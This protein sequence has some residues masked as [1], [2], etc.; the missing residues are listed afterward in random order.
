MQLPAPFGKYEL[1]ER[2][3]TGGMAE[4][5]L[6]RSFG[7]AGFEKRLVIKR[8]R[9][10]HAEDPRFI[11]MFINEAKIAV[12]LNH[13]N[14]VQVY[15]LGRVGPSWYIAMEHLHGRDLTRLVRILR[16][17]ERRLP[18][19]VAVHTV[20]EA[21]RGLHYAHSM[22]DPDGNRLG[23]VHRDVSPHNLV[24]TFDGEVKLVDFGV[25]RLMNTR[26]G[27][28][29][30]GGG[31]RPGG[32][33][34]AYMSPEQANGEEVDPRSDVFSAGIVLWELIAGHRLFQHEDAQEKLRRVREAVI[35]DLREGTDVDDQL[36]AILTKALAKERADRYATAGALEEDLRTWL[37][38]HY[39]GDPRSA[40]IAEITRAFPGESDRT[41]LG[42][43]LQRLVADVE[44]LDAAEATMTAATPTPTETPVAGRLRTPDGERK[45]VVCVVVDVDGLTDLSLKLEPEDMFKQHYRMLR[46]VR[47]IVDRY[48][49][50]ILTAIDDQIVLLFGARRNHRDDPAR[51]IEC[52]L[53]L[54][55]QV[56]SLR[57]KGLQLELAIGVHAGEV[58][59][60][61]GGRRDTRYLARGNTTRYARRLSARAD[62][63]E[64]LVS[65]GIIRAT[66]T[67]F[68]YTRGPEILNRGGQPP[69]PSWHVESRRH[70]LR[71]AGKGP[72]LRRG[73]ELDVIRD[74]LLRL[75]SGNGAMLAL[76]GPAGTGKSRL[77]REIQSL[78]HRRGLPIYVARCSPY[79]EDP[80]M[81]PF[82]DLVRSV[83]GLPPDPTQSEITAVL[84]RLAQLGL[85]PRMIEVVGALLDS[86]AA[87]ADEVWTA[88]TRIVQ[89]LSADGALVLAVEDL[90]FLRP[91]EHRRVAQLVRSLASRPIFFLGTAQGPLP[92]DFSGLGEMV[93]LGAF[94]S[95]V[96]RR[97]IAHLLD[98]ESIDPDLM[99]LI[100]RTCEGN[101]LYIEEMVKYL[102]QQNAVEVQDG[103][104][105]LSAELED[106][107]IPSTLTA[108]VASRI[109]ALDSASKGMLQLAAT[110]G[111]TFN[112]ALLAEAAGLDQPTPILTDLATN[113]LIQRTQTSDEWTFTSELVRRVAL[114]GI[115]GVQRRSYH[116]LI[117]SALEVQHAE[118]PGPVL[119][120]L[121][122]HCAEGRRYLDA[123]RYAYRAG[124]RL[125][126]S[127]LFERAAEFY[128]AGLNWLESAPRDADTYEP[129]VQG[130]AMI[131][132]AHGLVLLIMGKVKAGEYALQ[133]ALDVAS[134]IGLPWVE[135]RAH[136]ELGRSYLERGKHTLAKAHL[137]QARAMLAV[138]EDAALELQ[139]IEA[140]AVLAHEEGRNV[141]SRTLWEEALALAA[142][143]KAAQ[144][145]CLIG[146]AS[147][148]LRLGNTDDAAPTLH[149]ALAAAEAAGDPILQGRVLNNL[150]LL[151]SALG[152]H[153]E[154]LDSFR[155]ALAIREGIQYNRGVMAN[156]HNIGD[157]Y[158][159]QEEW[160]R[161]WVAFSRSREL[162]EQMGWDRGVALND[163]YMG[164]IETVRDQWAAGMIRM[165]NAVRT[166]KTFAD[167]E[168]EAFGLL[169]LA[170]SHVDRHDPESALP[171]LDEAER[172]AEGIEM[173]RMLE[174]IQELRDRISATSTETEG[175]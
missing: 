70:G 156:Y 90:H 48:D 63:G 49:G 92:S 164:Y 31:G 46:W 127:Q 59:T 72:W 74:N 88:L 163:T 37:F 137:Q 135:V 66:D 149:R 52:A 129:R 10:E 3:A 4:V 150:G 89:G 96:Q 125:E 42:L 30:S 77:I 136:L 98:A 15:D 50:V 131:R 18:L 123:A 110:I 173:A 54:K 27:S 57:T 60:A 61:S 128:S 11:S 45:A 103:R 58:T 102:I 84:P 47:H 8:I 21:C 39:R 139:T 114:H 100:E 41:P 170:R 13:P 17:D 67:L 99:H 115:L 175:H 16:S 161:A 169:L 126:C 117:A 145:R 38:D 83:L 172:A 108:V 109:D 141:K 160:S 95:H 132:L 14:V 165:Q 152:R 124:E 121:A 51:A 33:K 75:A 53:E 148:Q 25:A 162:A 159:N 174:T 24:V 7:V 29:T 133:L 153:E 86:R 68:R 80:A 158:F 40:L 2:I 78:A 155:Q 19:A 65:D 111:R 93:E 101:A 85:D 151:H 35:P 1:L 87:P 12:H 6:A 43:D 44:R 9:P 107:A 79:G 69:T 81:E 140:E 94:P 138:Q 73:Q 142:N 147:Q 5:Y 120:A 71:V 113:G 82:R 157:T 105:A 64:I 144:S 146:L 26:Q 122:H 76:V 112:G 171:L 167:P 97:L 130:E 32:G 143:E 56:G 91:A 34:Y 168:V 154:A 23:L 28:E 134:D 118:D 106:G 166:A 119:E 104:A 20:A 22:T 116:K 62:H 55:R 36:W